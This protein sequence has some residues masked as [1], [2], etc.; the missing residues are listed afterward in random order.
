MIKWLFKYGAVIF[1][2]NT[3][4]LSITSTFDLGNQIF[5][6]IMGIF[7]IF[8]VLNPTQVKTVIF[9]KAFSFLLIINIL[10]L[11]YFILFHSVSDI[12][13]LKYLLARGMQFSII[14]ISIYFHFDY[15]K[16]QFLNHIVSLVFFI[17]ILS[18]LFYPNIFSGRYSG[19]IWNSNMLASF[20]VIAFS[21]LLL[22]NNDKSLI[23]NILLFLFLVIALATGSRGALVGIA[24]SFGLKYGFSTRNIIYSI[25]A[26]LS[27]FLVSNL[28]L[29]TSLNRFA[30]QSMFNDRIGQ[31]L[32][33][34]EN[35]NNSLFSGYGLNEYTGLPKDIILPNRLK[36]QIMESHNGYLSVFLQYGVLF[37]GLILGL[38][39]VKAF[40]LIAF[41][42]GS[43][44]TEKVFIFIIIYTFVSSIYETLFTGINEFHTILFWLSLAF[45][46]YSKYKKEYES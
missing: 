9:H 6:A 28:N 39:F 40:Q 16:T 22:K 25:I 33:A 45:L 17:V 34:I 26:F 29:D 38:I 31:A 30:E 4:L 32:F 3:V 19:I 14:S 10:N 11:L 42:K 41:F 8:L 24:I 44:N 18:L 35:I 27:Y 12:E 1:L 5:L 23:D 37:G 7:T 15:Y 20:I 13:A 21:I 43:N 2:F 36:G 46:S